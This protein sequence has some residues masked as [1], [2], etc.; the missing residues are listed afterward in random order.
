LYICFVQQCI[1]EDK[2]TKT[3]QFVLMSDMMSEAMANFM[4]KISPHF[5]SNMNHADIYW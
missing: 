3:G 4:L 5:S 1:H 2:T